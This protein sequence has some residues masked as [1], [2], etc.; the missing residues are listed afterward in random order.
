M[1]RLQGLPATVFSALLCLTAVPTALAQDF[2]PGPDL[3]AAA[4]LTRGPYLQM[5][6]DDGITVRWRTDLATDSVVRYGATP[7]SLDMSVTVAGLRTEHEVTLTGLGAGSTWYYSVGESGGAIAGDASYF[8][9][10]APAQGVPADTRIWVLGDSGTANADARAVRDAYKAWAASDPADVVLMLG[11]N[12]YNDGTDAEYQAAVFD[13]YPEILRQLPLFSALGNH[14]GHSADSATQSGPYYDIFS[15][16][17][18]GEIGGLASGTEAYYSFDYANI[19]FVCLDSYETDRS[20]GGAMLTWLENDLA[21]NSQPWVVAFWHHPPYTKGS[22]DSD[23]EGRLIDM[24][25]DALPILE[26]WGVDLVLSGHSHSYERSF[27]LDG[28]YGHSTTLDPVDNVLDPGDGRDG[29]DGAYDKPDLIAAPH[30]GAVYAVAGSSGKVSGGSLDHPAMFVSLAS[31]GSLVL[32]VVGNRMDATFLDE[33]GL[34]RD[35]FTIVKS[36]DS[37]PPLLTRATAPDDTH[38]LVEFNEA[39]DPLEATDSGN[40]VIPGLSVFDAELLPDDRTVRL[41]T[42]P[43]TSGSSYTLQV[44]NV[45]DLALNTILPGSEIDFEYYEVVTLVFQDGIAPDPAYAGTRDSYLREASPTTN[46]GAAASLQVDGSEPSGTVTDMNIVLRWDISDVPPAVTVEAA[47]MTLNVTNVSSGSYS[48]FEVLSAWDEG[49]VTWNDAAAGTPWSGPGASGGDRGIDP[50]CLVSASATGPL[51]VDLNAAG[52]AMVQRWVDDPASNHGLVITDPDVGD[53]AD[54]HSRD[55]GTAMARPQLEVTYRVPVEPPNEDPVADFTWACTH[56]DCTFT[57]LSS[58]SDGS[59]V[60]WDWDFGD[61]NGSSMQDPAHSYASAGTRTVTLTVTDNDGAT[62]MTSQPVSVTEPPVEADY[63]ATAD[64]FGAGSVTGTYVDTHGDDGV[65]QVVQER[66]SGGKKS[67]RYSYLEHTWEFTVGAATTQTVIANAWSSGSSDGDEFLFEWS[68]GS[69]PFQ[70]LFTVSSTSEANVQSALISATGTVYIRVTD[71]DRTEG[72]LGLDSVIVDQLIIRADE[73][74]PTDPPG[75][76]LNLQVTAATSSS[77]TL[78][79]EHDGDDEQGFD[80]QRSPAG[81]GSWTD[82]PGPAAASTGYTDTGLEPDTAYDYRI[83]AWNAAGA[84]AWSNIASGATTPAP[85]ITLTATGYREK[86]RHVVDLEWSGASSP[87]VDIVRDGSVVETV[88]S[89]PGAYTDNIGA[90]GGA[91]YIYRV[92]ES[93]T[94][95]CSDDQVVVF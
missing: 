34:V 37:E 93:G 22:H 75:A 42:S 54:F 71:T 33:T 30:W 88:P 76:P 57:D 56:L 19:H 44:S 40:Y 52:L 26:D 58:D 46:Y 95:T 21:L 70:P 92:C 50:V 69:G 72:N 85:A 29:S 74:V 67:S 17:A 61:G 41:T 7:G 51:V 84:S 81:A 53:G 16:P 87:S 31:L 2:D 68:A 65:A 60:A 55:S 15:L 80:L 27:L 3:A 1:N 47:S 18:A 49:T 35:T 20:P 43:M 12:A 25:Q 6:T 39:L 66:Q 94:T 83:R 89:T 38:V 82:L 10:T 64:V 79:W 48:C 90:K 59:V 77:L 91:T 5:Q 9:S 13:T 4:A 11:D 73:T 28:H 8:F 78:S 86:G 24:R 45:Q 36:P 23:T 32:D 62:G 63:T 14:D